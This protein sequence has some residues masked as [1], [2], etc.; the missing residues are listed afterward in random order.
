MKQQDNPNIEELLNGFI[1]GELTERQRTEI[2][3]L[4]SHDAKVAQRLWE[5]QKCKML[6]GSLPCAEAPREILESIKTSMERRTLLG[7]EADRFDERK[8]AKH[9]L[10]RK[11]LAAAAMIGLVAVL[12]T[13]IYTIVAPESTKEK[14]I[15]SKDWQQPA[16]KAGVEST[17]PGIPVTAEKSTVKADMAARRFSARLELKTN[18]L[19]AVNAFINKAIDDNGLLDYV[20]SR[21]QEGKSIYSL[22]CDRESLSLMLADLQNIWTRFDSATLFVE[23]DQIGRQIVINAVSTKQINEIINQ[24]SFKKSIQ[25]A[26][27]FAVLN[28]IAEVL[29]G[30]NL[31]AAAEEKNGDLITIP[32]PVLTSNE[33]TTKKTASKAKDELQVNLIIVVAG[34]K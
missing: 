3:R 32:K 31:L 15:I 34:S 11:V 9:L 17:K 19:T 2:Q 7:Q 18:D 12:A 24:S 13:V 1:D 29:P 14:P 5:L 26:K 10:V 30:K 25:V 4:I 16:G 22:S 28:N 27:D 23:T 33:K 6:I 20:S 8:G 21:S